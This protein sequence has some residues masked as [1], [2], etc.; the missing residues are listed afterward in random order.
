[1]GGIGHWIEYN[2]ANVGLCQAI[3]TRQAA[4]N[5]GNPPRA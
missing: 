1:M 3:L 5:E 4:P 2:Q